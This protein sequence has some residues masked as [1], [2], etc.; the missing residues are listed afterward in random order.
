MLC[1][2]ESCLICFLSEFLHLLS[3]VFQGSS[4]INPFLKNVGL[5]L[6]E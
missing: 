3:D 1:Q 5:F 2:E 4:V 6:R